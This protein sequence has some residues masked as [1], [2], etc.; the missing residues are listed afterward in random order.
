MSFLAAL[1]L[2]APHKNHN[3]PLPSSCNLPHKERQTK[4]KDRISGAIRKLHHGIFCSFLNSIYFR[5][6]SSKLFSLL[7]SGWCYWKF[8]FIFNNVTPRMAWILGWTVRRSAFVTWLTWLRTTSLNS[9]VLVFCFSYEG[10]NAKAYILTQYLCWEES[11][12][13][14]WGQKWPF[15]PMKGPLFKWAQPPIYSSSR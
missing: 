12:C 6:I 13:L 4:P 8:N 3:P 5:G 7:C 2:S 1:I 9:R 14:N 15:P 10:K 11:C